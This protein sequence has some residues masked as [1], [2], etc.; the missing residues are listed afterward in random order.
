[1]GCLVTK[2]GWDGHDGIGI[3]GGKAENKLGSGL[4]G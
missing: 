4:C 2:A 1:M 3:N